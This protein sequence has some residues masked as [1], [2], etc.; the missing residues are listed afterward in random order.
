MRMKGRDEQE[1]L[2]TFAIVTTLH[3]QMTSKTLTYII[4]VEDPSYFNV[5]K[6]GEGFDFGLTKGL[7][8]LHEANQILHGSRRPFQM[9]YFDSKV[10]I[11]CTL[12][13]VSSIL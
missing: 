11:T 12:S 7:V 2:P 6:F 5:A 3:S 9:C 13:P 10:Q 1:R 4:G 8:Y